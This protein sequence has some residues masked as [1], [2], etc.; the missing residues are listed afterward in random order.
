MQTVYKLNADELNTEFLESVKALFPHKTIEVAIHAV[1]DE[2]LSLPSNFIQQRKF[3]PFPS[4]L[5]VTR[6]DINE[7]RPVY[8]TIAVDEIIIPPRDERYER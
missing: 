3:F 4:G 2:S 1:E 5:K 7:R 8:M 6:D